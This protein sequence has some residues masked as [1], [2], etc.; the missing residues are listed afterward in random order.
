MN[1]AVYN[2]WT[3]TDTWTLISKLMNQ[4]NYY[5]IECSVYADIWTNIYETNIVDILAHKHIISVAELIYNI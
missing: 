1:K 4:I 2:L 5:K 3:Y